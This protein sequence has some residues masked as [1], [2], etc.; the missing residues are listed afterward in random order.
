[1]K[2]R[3]GEPVFEIPDLD[4]PPPKPGTSQARLAAVRMNESGERARV[5]LEAGLSELPGPALDL[6]LSAP[7]SAGHGS[8][9]PAHEVAGRAGFQLESMLPDV[10][11]ITVAPAGRPNWPSGVTQD[12]ALLEFDWNQV[13][14]LARY[15][16]PSSIGALNVFYALRVFVQ[17]GRLR[18]ELIR[19][20]AELARA[21]AAREES[22]SRLAYEKRAE[23]AEQPDFRRLLQPLTEMERYAGAQEKLQK[24]SEQEQSAELNRLDAEVGPLRAELQE[25][26]RALEQLCAVQAEREQSL[27]RL[28]A[29]HKRGF[30]ELRAIEQRGGGSDEIERIRE[31]QRATLPA[32]EAAKRA[33]QATLAELDVRSKNQRE[34]RFRIGEL[35]RKKRDV[36]ARHERRLRASNKEF[37][38]ANSRYLRALADVGRAVLAARGGVS[39]EPAFIAELTDADAAVA[40][41]LS[42]SEMRVRALDACDRNKLAT[43]YAWLWGSLLLLVAFAAYRSLL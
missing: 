20:E 41:A 1:M 17:R 22:L 26:E 25:A 12:R 15:G 40:R 6:D 37:G 23:L 29:R 32:L 3:D 33:Y 28:E 39:V 10:A 5:T 27:T 16:A 4:L 43:G 7:I 2:S 19:C 18:R 30:I 34:L 11:G 14:A 35:E 8:D 9:L 21:E 13:Q 24:S 36:R 38:A 31:E 42:E